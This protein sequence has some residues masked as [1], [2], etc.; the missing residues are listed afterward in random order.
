MQANQ[1]EDPMAFAASKSD[2]NT[3]HHNKA[4]KAEDSPEFKAAMPKEVDAHTDKEGWEVWAK[5]DAP[6]GQDILPSVWS[7]KRKRRIYAREIHKRKARINAHGGKQT[8]GVNYWETHSPVVNW[9]SIRLCLIML[10]IFKWETRQIDFVLA[11]PQADAECDLFMQFPRGATLPGVHRSTHCLKLEKNLHG[12]RQAGQVWNRHLVEGPVNKMKF[13]Q[14][15]VNK[16]VFYRGTTILLIC[17]DDGI[18]CGPSSDKIRVIDT[19][20]GVKVSRPTPE[21][22]DLT[23]PHLIQQILDDM[24]MKLNAKTKEKAAPSSTILRQDLNGEPFN[25]EWDC[26]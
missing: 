8:H 26:R 24:G 11:F 12:T 1:A 3:M 10:L 21:T 9:F 4:M 20:L 15:A 2:P 16:C 7:F 19:C 5:A 25:E 6:A 14:S 22:I 13:K 18:L 17:V 23:Q